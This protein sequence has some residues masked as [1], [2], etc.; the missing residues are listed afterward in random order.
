MYQFLTLVLFQ[1]ITS[2]K[3]LTR[4]FIIV[5][6]KSF[7]TS[8]RRI[9]CIYVARCIRRLWDLSRSALIKIYN[10]F[11]QC[12]VDHPREQRIG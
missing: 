5:C 12:G 9:N 3:F 2:K 8:S 1:K 11:R 7:R 4:A 10:H 6:E